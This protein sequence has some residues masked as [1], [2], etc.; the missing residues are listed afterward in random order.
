MIEFL[1]DYGGNRRLPTTGS[2][3]A[4]LPRLGQPR[5]N[6]R[7]HSVEPSSSNYDKNIYLDTPRPRKVPVIVPRRL[8][9][10]HNYIRKISYFNFSHFFFFFFR[11]INI[12]SFY[13]I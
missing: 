5:N 6:Q 2:D 10:N 11:S 3:Y 1:D 7:C 4:T 13:F 8:R 9:S 12:I